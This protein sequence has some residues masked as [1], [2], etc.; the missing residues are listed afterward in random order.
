MKFKTSFIQSVWFKGLLLTSLPSQ[1]ILLWKSFFKKYAFTFKTQTAR[2]TNLDERSAITLHCKFY[3][4][5]HPSWVLKGEC[6]HAK[7]VLVE[8]TGFKLVLS[9]FQEKYFWSTLYWH[10]VS[11]LG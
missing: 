8:E 7:Y 9:S 1:Q 5:S 4:M 2:Y 10:D 11:L 3:E 6:Y